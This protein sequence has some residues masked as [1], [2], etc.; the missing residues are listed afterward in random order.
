MKILALNG[1]NRSHGNTA[2]VLDLLEEQLH[3]EADQIGETLDFELVS[4]GQL[5]LQMCRGCRICFDRGE[6]HCPLRD[7]LLPLKARMQAADALIVASPLYVD[8]VSRTTKNW[9]DRLAHLCHRPGFAGK[10]VYLLVTAGS[11]PTRHALQ[12]LNGLTYMGFQVIGR[13]GFKTGAL[14]KQDDI[15]TRH[16][17]RITQI[18]R[19]IVRAVQH[20]VG[21]QPSFYA[22]VVFKI[23]QLAWQRETP[24]SVD[25]AYWAGHGWLDP[26]RTFYVAHEASRLKVGLARLVG[27]VIAPFVI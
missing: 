11:S 18:A 26:R 23:Q 19:T 5:N 9:M 20:N 8:D 2:R 13:A 21:R 14:S 24:G 10:L 6:E 4:L 12:T 15:R 7:D 22:L 25:Y 27:A 16:G 17:A 1:S 3:R